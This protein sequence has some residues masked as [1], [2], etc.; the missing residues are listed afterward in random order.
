VCST[1]LSYCGACKWIGC[2]RCTQEKHSTECEARTKVKRTT[3]SLSGAS[4]E[5]GS[6]QPADPEE[7]VVVEPDLFEA[8]KRK[9][10]L[11]RRSQLSALHELGRKEYPTIAKAAEGM[12]WDDIK[13]ECVEL[14]LKLNYQDWLEL[15]GSV[16][17]GNSVVGRERSRFV[18]KSDDSRLLGYVDELSAAAIELSTGG[19]YAGNWGM[20]VQWAIDSGL[21]FELTNKWKSEDEELLCKYVGFEYGYHQNGY[22]TV[23]NKLYAIR[24]Y[25]MDAGY[26]NPLE[27]KFKLKRVLRGLKKLRGKVNRKTAVTPEHLQR[28]VERVENQG[29]HGAALAAALQLGFFYLLRIGEMVSRDS[30][31]S[32][33]FILRRCDVKFYKDG[34]LCSAKDFPTEMEIFIR[35]SKTDPGMQ[36][37]YRSHFAT[38]GVLCP[39]K[40]MVRWILLTDKKCSP[41]DPIFTFPKKIKG[42]DGKT[43]CPTVP[44]LVRG[45][46]VRILKEEAASQGLSEETVSTHGLRIG[47]ATAMH[48]AGAS[49]AVI[50]IL[51]RWASDVFKI[52]T[53]Y[54][55]NMMVGVA[56]EIAKSSTLAGRPQASQSADLQ[57]LQQQQRRRNLKASM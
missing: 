22:S 38:G 55:K 28:C 54:H 42:A 34:K 36:G 57:N 39:V 41:E 18:I 44:H 27:N 48:K 3:Q 17:S 20:F 51:G 47:G 16:V 40:A 5:A 12:S 14:L 46:V 2:K 33:K 50:Q 31:H 49:T 15:Y 37:C 53:R 10:S 45:D 9:I 56:A 52:Y 24:W 7:P 19:T 8:W 23:M 43:K 35:G 13:G 6:K 26:D 1:A 21:D 29:F 25:T 30:K 11:L 4:A 32:A